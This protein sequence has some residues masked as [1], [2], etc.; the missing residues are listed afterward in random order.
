MIITAKARKRPSVTVKVSHYGVSHALPATITSLNYTQGDVLGGG[1]SIVISGTNLDTVGLCTF[2]GTTA[3]ITAQT[4]TTLTV[5]L[6]AHAAG[7]VDVAVTNLG[8]TT[9]ATN[10]FEY[11]NPGVMSLTGWWRAF[12]GDPWSGLASAG[13]SGGRTIIDGVNPGTSTL[14]G[15]AIATYNGTSQYHKTNDITTSFFSPTAGT[16]LALFKSNTAPASTSAYLIPRLSGIHF[17]GAISLAPTSTVLRAEVFDLSLAYSTATTSMSLGV[18]QLGMMRFSSTLLECGIN[19]NAPAT[20]AIAGGG[21]N[22]SAWTSELRTGDD[23]VDTVF[24]DGS[25]A[26][27]IY[28]DSVISDANRTKVRLYCNQ[29]YGVSV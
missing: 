8:G 14:N 23:Y 9:T 15:Q 7:V 18:W 29:R 28:M 27:L 4:P 11:W 2:G 26:E 5:T 21:P 16:I 17:S 24:M 22:T 3:T 10:A 6:P 25:V 19:G 20:S 12:A 1:Q 13:A